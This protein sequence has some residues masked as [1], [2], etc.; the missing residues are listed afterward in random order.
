MIKDAG[1]LTAG[2]LCGIFIFSGHAK[3]ELHDLDVAHLNSIEKAHFT[4][5]V[6][7]TYELKP[8]YY[9]VQVVRDCREKSIAYKEEMKKAL[10]L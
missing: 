3:Q 7:T 5:C 1:L 8:N 10:G 6:E 4:S 9:L 2:F